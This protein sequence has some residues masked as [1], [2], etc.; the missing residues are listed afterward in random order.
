M[1]AFG[2]AELIVACVALAIGAAVVCG[3]LAARLGP[4]PAPAPP[5]PPAGA[6]ATTAAMVICAAVVAGWMVPTLGSLAAGMDRA[7]TLWYHMPLAAKFVQTG[8]LGD[9]FYFD[10]IFFASFY[11]SNSEVVHAVPILAFARDIVSPLLNLGYLGMGLL[12]C[13]CIGRPYGVAP[14]SLIGGAVALGAQMLVEFQA[15]EALNDITG[16]AFVLAAAALLVNGYAAGVGRSGTGSGW[17]DGRRIAT[18]ALV[19]GG[20]AAG[21]AAGVKLSFLAPVAALT[22][23]VVAIAPA[24][25]RRAAAVAWTAPMLLRR[26]LLVRAQRDRDG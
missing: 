20:L 5:G 10:P 22:V 23:G 9:I 11:P 8:S 2:E 26:H 7:D 16:V 15:G 3:R 13:W 21:L 25:M 24:G 1:G 12:A 19:V 4:R 17:P 6:M 14:Q 18:G